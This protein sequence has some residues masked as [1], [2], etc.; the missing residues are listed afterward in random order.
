MGTMICVRAVV[1][2]IMRIASAV[3]AVRTTICVGTAVHTIVTWV[4]IAGV[5][6]VAKGTI[7]VGTTAVELRKGNNCAV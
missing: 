4:R 3:G 6:G 5:V 1:H 2:T 7:C